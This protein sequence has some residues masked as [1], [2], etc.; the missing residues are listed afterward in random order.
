MV[1]NEIADAGQSDMI[2]PFGWWHDEHLIKTI[3]TPEKWCFEHTKCVEHIQD[4]GIPDMFE[5]DERVACDQEA[6]TIGRIGSTRQEE[7]RLEGLPKPYW[8]YKELFENEKAEM[9]APRRTFD[10][11]I[12]LN[13]G[14]TPLW[15]P[16]YPMSA[17]QLGKL[18]K[19][20]HKM[21]AQG[22]IVHSK[23]PA[24]TPILFVTKPDRK[25]RICVDYRQ[26][27]KLTILNKFP[28]LLMTELGERVACA[29]IFT[30]LDLKDGC[31][32]IRIKKGDEWQT[33]FRTQYGHY[34]YIV[35]PFGL[36][37]APPT[38]QALINTMLREFLDHGVVVYL[39]DILIYSK[40]MEE[41]EALVK[42]VLARL[43]RHH[44]AVS[45]K[46][47]LFHGDTVEF[48]GYMVGR[49]SVTMSEKNI[50][51]ILNWK[52]PWLVKDVQ[53]FIG[54]ANF[55]RRFI[56]NLSKVCKP[57]TDTLKTKG[58]KNLWVWAEE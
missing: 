29:T 33:A 17:Y 31:H 32:L 45:L 12:D 25:L 42:Q 44:L 43:E 9:L 55:Y 53:I 30:K 56:E 1:S 14:A 54:F 22:K 34:E 37:N 41:H 28:L 36:V 57:I 27:N 5:W 15:G 39:D 26:L 20:L 18:N 7:V 46:K 6:R 3:E 11:A 35:M 19:Y 58:G 50:E 52:A 13:D 48:L 21:L 10:D 24:G 38:F 23:S 2:I 49:T 51:S 40:T 8:Q 47:S 16:I 4:E